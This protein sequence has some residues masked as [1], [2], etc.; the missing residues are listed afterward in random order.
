MPSPPSPPPAP[1]RNAF[2][3]NCVCLSLL[4][5]DRKVKETL[6]TR[7]DWCRNGVRPVQDVFPSRQNRRDAIHDIA[8]HVNRYTSHECVGARCTPAICVCSTCALY[9][10]MCMVCT[11]VHAS[12]PL[13][14]RARAR[15]Y[16]HAHNDACGTPLFTKRSN[17]FPAQ[18]CPARDI[19]S[20]HEIPRS[21]MSPRK[22]EMKKKRWPIDACR[23]F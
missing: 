5:L 23:F 1:R 9:V 21:L 15:T 3:R 13:G 18:F 10:C 17:F 20:A 11:S 8:P 22:N 14:W 12:R 6:E 19:D 7:A 4:S 16:S 2:S